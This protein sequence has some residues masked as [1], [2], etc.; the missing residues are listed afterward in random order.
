[1]RRIAFTEVAR[2]SR[3]VEERLPTRRALAGS[4]EEER[5][6]DRGGSETAKDTLDAAVAHA[7]QASS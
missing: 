5:G 2:S 6:T 1:M 3:R 4:R 7:C